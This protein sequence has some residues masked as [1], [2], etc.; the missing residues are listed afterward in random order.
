MFDGISC[1]SLNGKLLLYYMGCFMFVNYIVFLEIVVVKVCKDVFFEKICYIG[2]GVII[3]I[4]VV[5]FIVNVEL[6]VVCVVFGFGGIGFN[7]I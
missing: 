5:M 2:C 3:G 1:F 6:N 4:G 7:V